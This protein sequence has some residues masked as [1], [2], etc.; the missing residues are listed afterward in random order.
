MFSKKTKNPTKN[1]ETKYT[2]FNQKDLVRD[3]ADLTAT[4]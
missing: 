1:K 4:I 3:G 2:I